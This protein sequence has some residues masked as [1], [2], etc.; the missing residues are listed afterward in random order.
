MEIITKHGAQIKVQKVTDKT[1][2]VRAC[3]SAQ[4]I[5]WQRP[6]GLCAR[7]RVQTEMSRVKL[8][9]SFLLLTACL[10]DR[11][12]RPRPLRSRCSPAT[13]NRP[14]HWRHHRAASRPG[15][16]DVTVR[17]F[18]RIDLSDADRQFVRESDCL[19]GYTR[20]GALLRALAPEIRAAA[21]RGSFVAGVGGLLDPEF[22]D[23]GFKRDA[24]LAAYFDA[25]G[26]ANL[27]QMVR[28]ALARQLRPGLPF[29]RL[30]CFLRLASLIRRAVPLHGLK[31]IPPPISPEN[32]NAAL[33][34]GRSLFSRA[35]PRL[36]PDRTAFRHQCRPGR[37]R[38][39][40][41]LWL[42][43]SSRCRFA[44]LVSR[45]QQLQ[46]VEASSD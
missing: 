16:K 15:L 6:G 33:V 28:A 18:P 17:S 45:H 38:L 36:R 4:P 31:T 13:R 10:F 41:P 8:F 37:A 32:L 39:Q 21:D 1:L 19:I 29:A 14:R 35:T 44:G 7:R 3:A 20:Y 27:V 22:A 25:G 34:P 5:A 26:Q 46:R 24:S 42:W 9:A 11:S 2:S 23:L 43:L 30:R 12:P 40:R